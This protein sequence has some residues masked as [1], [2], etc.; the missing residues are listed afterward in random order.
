[1]KPANYFHIAE[2]FNL[3][4]RVELIDRIPFEDYDPDNE[5][6]A[7]R[8]AQEFI[9]PSLIQA[10]QSKQEELRWAL[11]YYT[12]TD[13][14]PFQLFRDRCQ[15]L[16]LPD[17]D[18][19]RRFFRWIGESLYGDGFSHPVDPSQYSEDQDESGSTRLFH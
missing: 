12:T 3:L 15:D 16:S 10:N 18:D 13:S 9:R 5:S 2:L 6:D 11:E 19:W 8:I 1:M 4:E 14:A 7:R 17:S